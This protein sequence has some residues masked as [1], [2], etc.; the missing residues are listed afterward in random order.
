MRIFD[1]VN[2][3]GCHKRLIIKPLNDDGLYAH[4]LWNMENGEC[5]GSGKATMQELKEFLAH[6][7]LEFDK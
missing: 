3:L 7:G 2:D 4:T 1:Y 6:Y 5:C